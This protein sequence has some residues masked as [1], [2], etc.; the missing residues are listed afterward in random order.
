[1]AEAK[2]LYASP[3]G[4]TREVAL[5]RRRAQGV[6]VDL[7]KSDGYRRVGDDAHGMTWESPGAIRVRISAPGPHVQVWDS[8]GRS[9]ASYIADHG[10]ELESVLP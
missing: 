5:A 6:M 3:Y 4:E 7:L 8:Q 1:M 9:L 10:Y 2:D